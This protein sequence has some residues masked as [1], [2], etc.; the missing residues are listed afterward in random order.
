MI[1]N[2]FEQALSALFENMKPSRV[3][4]AMLYSL[5]AGGKR[6]RPKL[7]F[8][9]LESYGINAEEGLRT[10]AAIEMV[11][12]YSLIH[13]DLPAMDNDDLRRGKP[14]CHKQFDEA[15]AILAGDALLTEA[16]YYG[17]TACKDLSKNLRIAALITKTAGAEGMIFGQMLDLQ[18]EKKESSTIEELEMVHRYKTGALLTLP[19]L[20]AA[21]LAE[22]DEDIEKWQN[23]GEKLGYYFQ[24]QDDILD[25]TSS[26]DVLGKSTSDLENHKQTIATLLG[27]QK[28]SELAEKCYIELN[29]MCDKL[30]HPEA[31]RSNLMELHHRRQ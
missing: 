8:A 28:A 24:I 30:E 5:M 9:A 25:L 3:K 2:D 7:L 22:H 20:C 17:V 26:S 31:I 16:L 27:I 1:M 6:I 13:D 15:T 10:A 19:L 23:F 11:H 21:I 29:A 12:T 4:D 18:A 14:T